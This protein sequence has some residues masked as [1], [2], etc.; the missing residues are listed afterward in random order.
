MGNAQDSSLFD[1]FGRKIRLVDRS[2]E[3]LHAQVVEG[4]LSDHE[5]FIAGADSDFAAENQVEG[6]CFDASRVQ[7][8]IEHV[9]GVL[10]LIKRQASLRILEDLLFGVL[11]AVLISNDDILVIFDALLLDFKDPPNR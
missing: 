4:R 9:L 10:H 8:R 6:I 7:D 11:N 2:C 5:P 3:G 1:H